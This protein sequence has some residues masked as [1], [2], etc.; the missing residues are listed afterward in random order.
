MGDDNA[1][2]GPSDLDAIVDIADAASSAAEAVRLA[3][4]ALLKVIDERALPSPTVH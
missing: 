4:L 1:P 2:A 3:A